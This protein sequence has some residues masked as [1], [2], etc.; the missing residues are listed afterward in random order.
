MLVLSRKVGER[1]VSDDRVTI[2]INRISGNRV[3]IG[4]EAPESVRIVRGELAPIVEAFE[5]PAGEEAPAAD[6]EEA[7]AP[8]ARG[9]GPKRLGGAPPLSYH[10]P[11]NFTPNAPR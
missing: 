8:T 4:I 7:A 9:G 10:I 11:N 6:D 2:V 1:I 5:G 3:T